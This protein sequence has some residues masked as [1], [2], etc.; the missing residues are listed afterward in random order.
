MVVTTASTKIAESDIPETW[1]TIKY[2][3]PILPTYSRGKVGKYSFTNHK[4]HCYTVIHS[5]PKYDLMPYR[6]TGF[7]F[8]ERNR[9]Y[10]PLTHVQ[11]RTPLPKEKVYYEKPVIDT[12]YLN[13]LDEIKL[14]QQLRGVRRMKKEREVDE[15]RKIEGN[16]RNLITKLK[17]EARNMINNTDEMIGDVKYRTHQIN[18]LV[19]NYNDLMKC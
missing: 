9:N 15:I 5:S 19:R 16:Y 18:R 6:P 2:P 1:D 10:I 13:A 4:Y 3:K 17:Y 11:D 12:I 8:A 14:N 7:G